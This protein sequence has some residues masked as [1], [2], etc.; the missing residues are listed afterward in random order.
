VLEVADTD[1][2]GMGESGVGEKAG[3]EMRGLYNSYV[4]WQAAGETTP[5]TAEL[6]SA[7]SDSLKIRNCDLLPLRLFLLKHC[8][9]AHLHISTLKLWHPRR[10]Q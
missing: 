3:C 2:I 7:H 9:T 1:W 5:G 10:R 4:V 8:N 6:A